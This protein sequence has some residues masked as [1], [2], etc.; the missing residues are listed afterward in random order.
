MLL[1]YLS[2]IS[3]KC[4]QLTS[5][6]PQE[7]IEELQK[8][9]NRP[10]VYVNLIRLLFRTTDSNHEITATLLQLLHEFGQWDQSTECYSKNGWNLYLIG[11]EAGSCQWYELMYLVMKDLRKRVETEASYCWLSALSLLAQ[12]EH[13]LSSKEAASDLYI[14]SMLELRVRL[15]N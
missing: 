2:T 7:A 15:T 1:P 9:I 10:S 8:R 11:L 3:K 4:R 12:A 6:F 14:Q 13:S 5:W